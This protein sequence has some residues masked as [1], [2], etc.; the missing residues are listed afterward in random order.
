MKKIEFL[1]IVTLGSKRTLK[2]KK[3][4]DIHI[5]SLGDYLPGD[6]DFLE[7]SSWAQDGDK[8]WE[9]PPGHPR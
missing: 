4:T 6:P 3:K 8:V 1:R 2:K 5:R 7:C 9:G